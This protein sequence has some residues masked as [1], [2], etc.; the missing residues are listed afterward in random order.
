MNDERAWREREA[1]KEE[2]WGTSLVNK[3]FFGSS[4]SQPP[5]KRSQVALSPCSV[6]QKNPPAKP[7]LLSVPQ[8]HGK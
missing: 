1:A 7:Y 6:E 4:S 2:H 8:N 5:S 3:A